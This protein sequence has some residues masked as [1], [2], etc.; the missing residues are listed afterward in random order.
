MDMVL[1]H[2][3]LHLVRLDFVTVS[4]DC[5]IVLFILMRIKHILR[6]TNIIV[7]INPGTEIAVIKIIYFTIVT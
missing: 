4:F 6:I 7:T 5:I 3:C 2:Q 1:A